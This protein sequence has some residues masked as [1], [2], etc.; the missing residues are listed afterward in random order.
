MEE[1]LCCGW[2]RCDIVGVEIDEF[3]PLII[4]LVVVVELIS[5][6]QHYV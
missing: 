5:I 2:E 1:D 4:Y 6:I 3:V